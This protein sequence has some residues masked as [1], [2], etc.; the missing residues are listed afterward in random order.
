MIGE[1]RVTSI[2]A[3]SLS[4]VTVL[5][6]EITFASAY[7]FKNESTAFTPS[8]FKKKVPGVKPWPVAAP[9]P[10]APMIEF[11]TVLTLE[12]A[13]ELTVRPLGRVALVVAPGMVVVL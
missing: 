8:A 4:K 2:L 11:K 9:R 5:G 13:V 7:L 12:S 3:V 10:P 1:A 6:V